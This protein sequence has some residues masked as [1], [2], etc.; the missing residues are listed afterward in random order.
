M[1]AITV[2]ATGRKF[3]LIICDIMLREAC[4]CIARSRNIID[5]VFMGKGLHNLTDGKMRGNL[6]SEIDK[7]DAKSYDA[8]LLGYGLCN[9]GT[10]HLHASIPLV[11]PKAHDCISLLLGSK[12]KYQEYF[13]KNPGTYYF[14]PGWIER[15][16]DSYEGEQSIP[17]QLGISTYED[18]VAKYGEEDAQYIMET[19][20]GGLQQYTKLA[21][22]DTNIGE[23]SHYESQSLEKAA[24]NGWAFEK[25]AG[26]CVLLQKLVD[27]DWPST[28]FV[29]VQPDQSIQPTYDAEVLTA[30]SNQG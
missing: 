3:K 1:S 21:Y 19:L 27:G 22:I 11:I 28:E 29:V 4:F 20:G 12:E 24:Q 9:N 2:Q 5:P 18:Y 8:I 10:R 6:Q 13:D 16:T 15:N 23:F 25:L 14:S 17:Q 30:R 26:S 7:V